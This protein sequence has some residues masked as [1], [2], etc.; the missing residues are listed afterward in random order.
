MP[1]SLHDWHANI[2]VW[3]CD[4]APASRTYCPRQRYIRNTGSGTALRSNHPHTVVTAV[5]SRRHT[6]C[7]RDEL[8][9]D[10]KACGCIVLP[11][12][13][14][15][16]RSGHW[17]HNGSCSQN[18]PLAWVIT[19]GGDGAGLICWGAVVRVCPR[20][21]TREPVVDSRKGRHEHPIRPKLVQSSDLKHHGWMPVGRC[22]RVSR[23]VWACAS[24][25]GRD[26]QFSSPTHTRSE[27]T[28]E[29]MHTR[30]STE[31]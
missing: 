19:Q 12:S 4:G 3:L 30:E 2:N 14:D 22:V 15:S 1:D 21:S 8:G 29:V 28:H 11:T 18:Q 23:C 26:P 7:L 10:M 13:K 6:P 17:S 5:C 24:L 31:R 9:D 20:H 16:F 25:R 27:W